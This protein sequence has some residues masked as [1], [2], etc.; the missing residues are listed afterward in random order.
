MK[1]F[2]ALGFICFIG[3]V[4]PALGQEENETGAQ[5]LLE[6]IGQ[7]IENVAKRLTATGSERDKASR[8]LQ[9]I[10]TELAETHQR[11]DTLQSERRELD[12]KADQ[13]RQQRKE[14]QQERH[15]QTAA[16]S[17]QLVA[18]HRLGPTLQI[19][20]LLNQEDP[21][22]LDRMQAYLNRLGQARQRR[23]AAIAKLDASLA[24]SATELQ[25]H[26]TRL[27][28]LARQ[29][30]EQR[31]QLADRTAQ[32]QQLVSQLDAR[33]QTEEQRLAALE[34]DQKEARKTL[35]RIREEMVSLSRPSPS[36]RFSQTQGDMPWPVQGSLQQGFHQDTGVHREGIMIQASAGTPVTAV[37][38]GR[39]VFADWMRG[40]GNLLII[41]H[42]DHMM[43]LYAHLQRF[44][45]SPG[46]AVQRGDE[47]GRVGDTGG[48]SRAGLYFEVR[49]RGEPT[50][51]EQW[52][53]RR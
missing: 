7:K 40:F 6:S 31:E 34:A 39:V 43:T 14:L 22:Q 42:G 35:Q 51:P 27:D 41:D 13:L 5:R 52:I 37:H 12:D 17:E 23:M 45:I 46:Q 20:L 8:E 25:A 29:L 49:Q 10:E 11:L 15:Q 9:A 1:C 28:E 4:T 30:E 18:L 2:I 19:K 53:A 36:T 32:R 38:Q 3:L 50:N 21:A 47:I 24:S 44:S 33:H 26:Q 16:L 48:Q